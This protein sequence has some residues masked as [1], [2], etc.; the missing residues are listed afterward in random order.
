MMHLF[1]DASDTV[2][3]DAIPLFTRQRVVGRF[4]FDVGADTDWSG[5]NHRFEIQRLC[6]TW[7]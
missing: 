2:E 5:M 6:I 7:N 3:R 4:D 1:C